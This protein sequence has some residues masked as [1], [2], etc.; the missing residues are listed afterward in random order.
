MDSANYYS[1]KDFRDALR[2]QGG[3]RLPDC[4][5]SLGIDTHLNILV[6]NCEYNGSKD[7]QDDNFYMDQ[8]P[9]KKSEGHH[10]VLQF[11]SFLYGKDG[12]KIYAADP[13]NLDVWQIDPKQS[14]FKISVQGLTRS[15]KDKQ[16]NVSGI[17]HINVT[18]KPCEF[19]G[20]YGGSGVGKTTFLEKIL[21]PGDHQRFGWSE[22]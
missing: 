7:D 5:I 21:A 11:T 19:V 13:D 22:K 10:E 14:G 6:Q 20:I 15:F 4:D 2:E 3:F 17:Q 9:Y 1:F 12:D 18:I 16:G 8:Y